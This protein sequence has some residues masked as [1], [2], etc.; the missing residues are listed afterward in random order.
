MTVSVSDRRHAAGL[1]LLSLF[2]LGV[3]AWLVGAAVLPGFVPGWR[4]VVVTSGS[5]EPGISPGDVVLVAPQGPA[6]EVG[7]VVL[8][9]SPT[10]PVTHRI[11]GVNVDGTYRTRGDANGAPDSTPLRSDHVLGRARLVIPD[12]GLPTLWWK[13]GDLAP[14]VATILLLGV[15]SAAL[16]VS[17]DVRRLGRGQ[18]RRVGTVGP[19]PTAAT[20]VLCLA[21]VGTSSS[22][23]TARAAFSSATSNAKS[24][25]SALAFTQYR[26]RS[27]GPGDR[28][29]TYLPLASPSSTGATNATL[30]NYDV[31][32]NTDPGLT[33][34][35]S[36]NGLDETNANR[37]Q[38]WYQ[39][40]PS[41]GVQF[42][43][44]TR[45]RIWSAMRNFNTTRAGELMAGLYD[46]VIWPAISCV[47]IGSGTVT[48]A[49]WNPSAGWR[50]TTIDLGA[51][52]TTVAAG[53]YLALKVVVG[54]TAGD[55]MWLAYDTTSHPA[56]LE[57]LS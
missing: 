30:P 42:D 44:A 19:V 6:I 25:F 9:S 23:S 3:A 41:A 50:E 2:V 38:W 52:S 21:L 35:P 29:S 57:V 37:T 12:A 18:L 16:A 20:L 13:Q 36:N 53:H 28:S 49:P 34:L 22:A 46:C 40:V 15:V 51:L 26:L 7:S 27:D 11:V 56:A 39:A 4:S 31:D 43:G 32:R 54:S 10:G 24:R 55:R 5:M 48:A 8:F 33:L 45:V 14:L 1:G 17:L 47:L